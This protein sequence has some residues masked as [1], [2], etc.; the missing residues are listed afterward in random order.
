VIGFQHEQGRYDRRQGK[1]G[2]MTQETLTENGDQSV[3]A[4]NGV[5]EGAPGDPMRDIVITGVT[6]T[7]PP[8]GKRGAVHALDRI[9][10]VVKD[11]EFVTLLGPS[12][13]GKSTLL[14]MIGGLET[15]TAGT[16]THKNK[17]V[18][19]PG[20]DRGMVFQSYTLFPWLT[21]R[22]NIQFGLEQQGKVDTPQIEQIADSYIDLVGLRGFEDLYPKSLSGGMKQRVAIARALAANPDVLLLDEPF[23]ALDMQT[24]IVMQELLLRVWQK[25]PTTIVMVTHDIDEAILLADRTVVMSARPGRIKEIM[26]ID[27]P[28]PRD[29]ETR[30]SPEFLAYR[31]HAAD[32]IREESFKAVGQGK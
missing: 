20:S 8:Q 29:Y 30:R 9:D 10:L 19:G 21:V 24:R 28:R 4:A 13:C 23:A 2:A 16:I 22:K 7:F 25:S 17:V 32:L 14:R 1:G 18:D 6:K 5:W 11:R 12:G 27:I 26:D 31:D 3:M 15:P